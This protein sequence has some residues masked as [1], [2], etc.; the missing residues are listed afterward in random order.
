MRPRSHGN[1]HC[2]GSRVALISSLSPQGE[3]TRPRDTHSGQG[4]PTRAWP[5]GR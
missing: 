2:C 1:A 5:E 3:G 4:E